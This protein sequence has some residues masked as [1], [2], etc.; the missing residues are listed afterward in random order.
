MNKLLTVTMA[1]I[2]LSAMIQVTFAKQKNSWWTKRS[3]PPARLPKFA[4][5]E[6]TS[7]GADTDEDILNATKS[8]TNTG[9]LDIQKEIDIAIVYG[10]FSPCFTYSSLQRMSPCHCIVHRTFD[11]IS[12]EEETGRTLVRAL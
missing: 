7:N 2:I 4:A 10:V 6:N 5:Q 12:G 9:D 1:T 11:V 3:L 8:T